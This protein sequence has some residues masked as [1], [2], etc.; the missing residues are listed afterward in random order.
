MSGSQPLEACVD[1]TRSRTEPTVFARR[2]FRGL[3]ARYDLL[4]AV[5]SF[6][7]DRRWRRAM[8]DR[9]VTDG[10]RPASVLDVATGTAG[11]ALQIARRTG[12]DVAGIDLSQEMLARG[13]ENVARDGRT[14][15]VRLVNGRAEQ[16]PFPDATFDALTFTYLLR[17]VA[18]PAAT[19]AELARVVK[20]GGVVASLEFAVPPSRFWRGWWHLYTR[21]VLPTAGGLLGGRA[22]FD[23]GRFLGPSIRAHDRAHPLGWV[24]AAWEAA[25]MTGVG[26]RRMS[27]GGGVV[28]W[29]R[30]AG[31]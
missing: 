16:L 18:D 28:M 24:T 31:G 3:P 5:L 27:L 1:L 20:P 2:L 25:G 14:G 6:G 23:V 7:Q 13:R 19:V 22:W 9:V 11:V 4:G 29:G 26:A 21:L 15:Q 17:Y 30:R 12:A 10:P 8:V